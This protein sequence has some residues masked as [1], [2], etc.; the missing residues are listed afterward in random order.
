MNH[1]CHADNCK[2]SVPPKMFMCLPHWNMVPKFA[3]NDIWK[4]YRRGQEIDKNPSSQ[5]I[6]AT[7]VARMFVAMREKGFSESEIIECLINMKTKAEKL[8]QADGAEEGK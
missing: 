5:Y 7:Q 6:K 2:R 1:T 8:A 4:T 3:Q